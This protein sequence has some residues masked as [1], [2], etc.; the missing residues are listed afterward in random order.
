L[1]EKTVCPYGAWRSP[2]TSE[3][4][5]AK[6]IGLREVTLAGEAVYWLELRPEE[7]GRCV[8]V[9]RGPEGALA[10]QNP[11]PFN[12]RTRVHEY[13][14]GAYLVHPDSHGIYFS[15]FSD[16]RFYR[17]RAGGIPEAITPEGEFR[18]A[19]AVLDR[20]RERLICVREDHTEAGGEPQ[21]TLVAVS[22][23]AGAGT[24]VR[25][26]ASGA[27]FYSSPR[28][29]PDG[30]HLTWI[31]WNHPNMPW[32]GTD[33]WLAPVLAD[34]GLGRA[35]RIA[36]GPAES[37]FQPEWSPGGTLYFVSDRSGFWN[38]YRRRDGQVKAVCPAQAEFGVPQWVFRESTY[39]FA[40]E[41]RIVCTF[42]RE[43]I[44]HLA[45]LDTEIGT[46]EVIETP[47]THIEGIASDG[48]R[49]VFLASSPTDFPAIVA[50]D[51]ESRERIVLR[52]SSTLSLDPAFI[53]TGESIEFPTA[54][55]NTAHGFFYA[56]KSGEFIGPPDA[57]PPLM[58]VSHGGPTG[59]ADNG[60]KVGIQFFTTRGFAVL[61][62]NYG[63][64][65]GFGRAYR[66][67]LDGQWGVVDVDDCVYG[68]RYLADRGWV[69]G[70]RLAIRGGSAGGFTTLAAL[71]FR[72][73]FKAGASH[74]GVSDLE[75]LAQHTHKFESRYLERLIGPYPERADLYRARSPIHAVE[76]L[77]CPV[78]FFQGLED[79]VVP[80]E[81]AEKMVE[82]LRQKKLPVAY[83]AFPGEQHGFRQ[84]D[85]IKR[86]L[87]AELYFYS[88]VF[89]FKPA[90]PLEP[91][92][93]D[94]LA[95]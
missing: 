15:N 32:E 57:R 63:G 51:L 34:G 33:L 27:D 68:A 25:V 92:P 31:S 71:T 70:E 90:D 12:A 47:Y 40:S 39:A 72:D 17:V 69:D 14:G 23:A 45:I 78:I 30:R 82:A 76:R 5:V 7:N 13:G 4:I 94:N 53:A 46:L 3:L 75:A 43:G 95:P 73:V 2:V 60:L 64:S 50:L 36:G 42:A 58:V 44:S 59:S 88:R 77:A 9:R 61:D 74:F 89:G 10:D 91:V 62:V 19:D 49:A 38:L 84:A 66:Q 55:G 16:Q 52:R 1:T 48:R 41:T 67:R 28:L 83:L 81:Q 22:L 18:Y 24:G 93:I 86:V 54:S 37:I 85:T 80:P 35:E 11:A 87:D 6:T 65:S 29:C 20:G 21:N 26:L 56:P 79:R 8:V